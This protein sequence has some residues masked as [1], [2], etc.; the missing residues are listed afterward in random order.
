MAA[1][2]DTNRSGRKIC[3]TRYLGRVAIGN[4]PGVLT[5]WSEKEPI[6]ASQLAHA[7]R[8]Q[9]RFGHL[10]GGVDRTYGETT[11]GLE[12]SESGAVVGKSPR[13]FS[14]R[15]ASTQADRKPSEAK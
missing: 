13:E 1:C 3:T 8:R 2:E 5:C 15:N 12:T 4:F 11:H 9:C 14:R 7:P 10:S 6:M